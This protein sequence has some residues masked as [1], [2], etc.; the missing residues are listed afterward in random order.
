MGGHEL[1]AGGSN[2]KTR[3]Q[4]DCM[5]EKMLFRTYINSH[6]LEENN[7]KYEI[8][9]TNEKST[10]TNPSL[11]TTPSTVHFIKRKLINVYAINP[12]IV[13]Q[14]VKFG[15]DI[16]MNVIDS[17]EAFNE[18]FRQE[19]LLKFYTKNKITKIEF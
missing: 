18:E 10:T 4:F 19:Q 7:N 9:I 11:K 2:F 15:S 5:F 14:D 3:W 12:I 6:S 13:A 1:H 17:P 16:Q 8:I